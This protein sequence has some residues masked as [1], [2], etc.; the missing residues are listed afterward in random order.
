[1]LFLSLE[2]ILES[3]QFQIDSYGGSPGVRDLGLLESAVAQ[4]QASFGGQSL[5]ANGDE[6]AAAS[7][8]ID[9]PVR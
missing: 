3:H 2:D 8:I 9:Q 6:M 1:V 7:L 4:P 5:L